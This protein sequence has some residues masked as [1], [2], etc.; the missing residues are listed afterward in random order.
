MQITHCSGRIG[1]K[2]RM[3]AASS[4]PRD[5]LPL[6]LIGYT[7]F[8]VNSTSKLQVV[9]HKYKDISITRLMYH[10]TIH[11]SCLHIMT[12]MLL[13]YSYNALAIYDG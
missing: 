2:T 12:Y 7:V 3:H 1:L 11:Y 10:L 9:N 4:W 13:F 5:S 6:V 8:L